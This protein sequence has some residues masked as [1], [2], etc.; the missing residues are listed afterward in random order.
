[1]EVRPTHTA[2]CDSII[3][4]TALHLLKT[5]LKC[6]ACVSIYSS[7]SADPSQSI[8][9]VGTDNTVSDSG[10]CDQ[11]CDTAASKSCSVFLLVH[12]ECSQHFI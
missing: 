4:S 5:F 11:Q 3:Q 12:A 10:S 8:L 2:H 7:S 6:A 9:L 1:M